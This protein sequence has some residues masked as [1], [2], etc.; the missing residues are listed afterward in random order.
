MPGIDNGTNQPSPEGNLD[1]DREHGNRGTQD[2][3]KDGDGTEG[4][5]T[6]GGGGDG[7]DE[8]GEGGEGEDV[9][10][11]P[12]PLDPNPPVWYKQAQVHYLQIKPLGDGWSDLICYW[13]GI[14]KLLGYKSN[15]VCVIFL[16][17]F[18]LDAQILIGS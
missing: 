17:H 5:E 16:S 3:A 11:M 1:N 6:R 15:T 18:V 8:G 2:A 7:G 10:I 4:D 9:A 12:P 14:Q 13:M